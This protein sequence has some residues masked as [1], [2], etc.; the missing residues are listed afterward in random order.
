MDLGCKVVLVR[1]GAVGAGIGE[2]ASKRRPTNCAV[3]GG[4][5]VGNPTLSEPTTGACA[6]PR[7]HAAQLLLTHEDLDSR[8]RISTP[9]HA[10]RPVRIRAVPII[11]ENDT[12]SVDEIKFG[13]NDRLAAMVTNLLQPAA[14]CSSRTSKA[15]SRR[16]ATR[17]EPTVSLVPRSRLAVDLAGSSHSDGKG[18][19]RA[20]WPPHG[21]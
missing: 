5:R 7:S 19:M 20:S 8:P 14:W 9:Q 13:D 17:A 1:S 12:I 11:N 16:S 6:P 15:S 10:A 4:R 21:W 2:R 18:G 3:P